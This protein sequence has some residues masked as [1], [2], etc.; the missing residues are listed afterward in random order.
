MSQSPPQTTRLEPRQR[1][2][3]EE[4]ARRNDWYI[5][6][7]HAIQLGSAGRRALIEA[8]WDV[9][10]QEIALWSESA[11][12]SGSGDMNVLDAGCG[13][14]I[15]LIGLTKALQSVGLPANLFGTDYNT[16]RAG[17]SL[18]LGEARGICGASLLALPFAD[19][20]FDIILCNHVLEHIPEDTQALSELRRVLRPGGLMLIGVPNEGCALAWLR[21]H[22]L[23]PSIL[24]TTD[25]L[26][27]HTAASLRDR[28]E[29]AGMS[30]QRI[31]REGFFVPHLRVTG[32]LVERGWGRSIM[33]GARALVPSQAAGLIAVARR[34]R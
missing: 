10:R 24:K 22:V 11:A 18:E 1:R 20:T 15:N 21:N 17:R 3:G 23:Q 13:D 2:P 7:Q 27:F 19:A 8:R 6:D 4:V 16:L 5:D 12:R 32:Y 30:V 29:G 33:D 31:H 14:G 28:I 25:H 9:L 26:H 34:E